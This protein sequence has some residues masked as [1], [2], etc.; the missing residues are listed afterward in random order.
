MKTYKLRRC[1]LLLPM[2]L[3]LGLSACISSSIRPSPLGLQTAGSGISV[4]P[5]SRIAV[6]T[7]AVNCDVVNAV[8][9]PHIAQNM[10]RKAVDQLTAAGFQVIPAEQATAQDWLLDS[11]T[12]CQMFNINSWVYFLSAA[13]LPTWTDLAMVVTS[14]VS[15]DGELLGEF[16]HSYPVKTYMSLY[17]PGAYFFGD[18]IG[19]NAAKVYEAVNFNAPLVAEIAQGGR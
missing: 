7:Q 10:Q 1:S 3:M 19:Q 16:R 4:A 11:S 5:G 12:T 9:G 13:T 14:R 15:R 2:V 17:A 8:T 18:G 6:R